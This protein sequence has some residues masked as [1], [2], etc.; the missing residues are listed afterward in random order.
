MALLDDLPFEGTD[1]QEV[2]ARVDPMLGAAVQSLDEGTPLRDGLQRLRDGETLAQIMGLTAEDLEVLYALGIRQIEA[3]DLDKAADT[4]ANL[5]Q[6]DPLEARHRY[7]M[8][9][10]LQ[11]QGKLQP[12]A[13][14]Y[15][16][17][18]ALD[19][20][21]PDGYMRL[22]EL[23]LAAGELDEAKALFQ[24]TLRFAGDAPDHAETVAQAKAQLAR[25]DNEFKSEGV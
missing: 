25:F 9:L 24:E 12:A 5:G 8:A 18:L 16:Q 22:A 15:M 2:M 19:A 14:M 3:R 10:V 4:F 23:H 17:F 7:C 21:N 6:I 13:H 1:L 20:T 11:L